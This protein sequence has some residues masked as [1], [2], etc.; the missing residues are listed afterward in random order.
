MTTMC[1]GFYL[2]YKDSQTRLATL[3]EANAKLS[4]AVK[5]NEETIASMQYDITAANAELARVNDS[6]AKVRAQNN[7]LADRLA[8]HD[9]GVLASRKPKLVENTINAASSK[10]GRCFELLSGAT[11]TDA[12]RNAVD[13]KSFNSECPWLFATLVTR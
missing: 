8:Q 2:Y 4:V 5:T 3:Q 7:E 11:L 10:A 9:I 13:G 6:F 1:G 12:E